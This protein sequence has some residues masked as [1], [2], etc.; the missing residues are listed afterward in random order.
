MRGI[1]PGQEDYT[2]GLGRPNDM[3]D[4]ASCVL[5]S[6]NILDGYVYMYMY[7]YLFFLIDSRTQPV[8]HTAC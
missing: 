5:S 1:M 2:V 3:I 8:L 7:I 4:V 6:R